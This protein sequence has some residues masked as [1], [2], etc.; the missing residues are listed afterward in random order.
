MILLPNLRWGHHVARGAIRKAPAPA[1]SPSFGKTKADAARSEISFLFS[2]PP[3]NILTLNLKAAYAFYSG[4][5]KMNKSFDQTFSTPRRG[6]PLSGFPV[7]KNNRA[8]LRHSIFGVRYSLF[9]WVWPPEA[10]MLLIG[11]SS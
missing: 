10:S 2:K 9:H 6:E 11:L 3:K 1:S 7:T 4:K 8:P 5:L